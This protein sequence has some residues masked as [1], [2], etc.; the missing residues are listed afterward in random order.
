M[1]ERL[2]LLAMAYPEASRKYGHSVCI[3]GITDKG[4]FRRIYPI[5]YEIWRRGI[6]HKRRFIEYELRGKGDYRKE[7]YKVYT[8]T[9]RTLKGEMDYNTEIRDICQRNSSSVEE[10]SS[11]FDEDRTSIGIVKPKILDLKI[12]DNIPE[13]T[14][15]QTLLVPESETPERLDHKFIYH[16]KCSDTCDT[17]HKM[18]ILDTEAGQLYRNLKMQMQNREMAFIP[19][20]KEK[21]F[22]WMIKTRD[23][24]FML[25]THAYHPN[26]WMIISV[27]YPEKR[28]QKTLFGFQ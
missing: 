28:S 14:T 21:F 12:V 26:H 17:I 19:K 20:F 23:P 2:L 3:A 27:L 25:G 1:K 8:N 9:I 5:P 4:E 6:F 13:D 16:F 18:M 7:S 24:F 15:I 11:A 22:T 10:L